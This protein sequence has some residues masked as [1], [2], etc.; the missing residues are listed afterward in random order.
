MHNLIAP[1]DA[2]S[3]GGNSA[4]S[5]I[6]PNSLDDKRTRAPSLRPDVTAVD[7]MWNA[8]AWAPNNNV[9]LN[10]RATSD[11]VDAK[12]LEDMMVHDVVRRCTYTV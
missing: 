12:I 7:S 3:A 9:Q 11:V 5:T 8:P 2:G 1:W 6:R 4:A 10:V